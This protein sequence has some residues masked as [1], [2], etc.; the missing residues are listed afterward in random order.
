MDQ[1]TQVALGAAAAQAVGTHTLGRKAWVV[2]GVAALLPDL[3]MAFAPL[4]DPLFPIELH[5]TFTHGLVMV[6]VLAGLT[7]LLLWPFRPFRTR[8]G[9]V[10]LAAF[11]AALTHAPLD[12]LTSYGTMIL[13]PFSHDWLA[14]D[15]VSVI[16]PIYTLT[17][18]IGVVWA[19]RRISARPARVALVLSCLWLALGVLQRERALEAQASLAASRGHE[20]THVRVIPSLG[21]PLVWRS[22]YVHDGRMYADAVRLP[23]FA[24]PT[25]QEAGSAVAFT[26]ADIP[27]DTP[28]GAH[29]REVFERYRTFADGLIARTP[30]D[31][32]VVGDMRYTLA[33][34]FDPVWGMRIASGE[35]ATWAERVTDRVQ[36]ILGL[37]NMAF[38][39][40]GEFSP[41][42]PGSVSTETPA[43]PRPALA[44]SRAPGGSQR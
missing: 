27:P 26:S 4:A 18:V 11:V 35:R 43:P 36:G 23:P 42:P 7:V 15:V 25:F 44:E 12:V 32:A 34:G 16:D 30:G 22:L 28:D 31:E 13:W 6:P 41:L 20:P 29:V 1:L 40:S 21:G 33:Y 3:D 9:A 8:L 2:G 5:R 10:F 14:W 17:L 19:A 39:T 37:A 38:G 24:A